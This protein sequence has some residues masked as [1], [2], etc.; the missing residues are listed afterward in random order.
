MVILTLNC[1]YLYNML[2][3]HVLV[4][5]QNY[6]PL[7]ICNVKRAIILV[8]KGK[9]E[10]IER[11]DY[12]IRSV[13]GSFP[14]PSVVRLVVYI[15]APRNEIEFSRRNIIKRDR[16]QCQY[17]GTKQGPMTTDHVI[18]R[19]LGGE[20]NWENL[21]CAC[22]VCNK[23][24]GNKTPAQAGMKLLRQPRKPHRILFIHYFVTIPD[25]RWKP[26]LFMGS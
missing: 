23:K 5:N 18:P 22:V 4:L 3:Q 19:T 7:S 25:Q 21:V 2:N 9:A 8:Y 26:Y 6:E 1:G 13:S 17:C 10:I 20:D 11:H 14:L 15:K 12:E 16:H 24:K